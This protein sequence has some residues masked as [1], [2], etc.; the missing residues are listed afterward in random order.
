M[1]KKEKKKVLNTISLDANFLE[2]NKLSKQILENK[3]AVYPL[4]NNKYL[5]SIFENKKIRQVIWQGS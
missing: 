5:L 2:K 3:T 4:E 1:D